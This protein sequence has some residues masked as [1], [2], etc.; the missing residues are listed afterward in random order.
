MLVTCQSHAE[1][2]RASQLCVFI[3][4]V[5]ALSTMLSRCTV[6]HFV[7]VCQLAPESWAHSQRLAA[8]GDCRR[9]AAAQT[10]NCKIVC[11]APMGELHSATHE[12]PTVRTA[13]CTVHCARQAT[14]KPQTEAR[15]GAMAE[16]AHRLHL[17]HLGHSP[18]PSIRLIDS[19][20]RGPAA[21]H[22]ASLSSAD[23][24]LKAAKP[25]ATLARPSPSLARP[26]SRLLLA[27]TAAATQTAR[28]TDRQQDARSTAA[29]SPPTGC[30]S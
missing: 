3:A 9:L 16:G 5:V 23:T 22:S 26:S 8:V 25:S 13:L 11:A 24:S 21:C 10:G 7:L 18:A 30:Q 28:Q 1:G 4:I 27:A 15:S 12:R 2:A 29:P 14:H 6:V 17:R 20:P 19:A